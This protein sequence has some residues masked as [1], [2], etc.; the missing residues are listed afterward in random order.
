[1]KTPF[2]IHRCDSGR[3]RLPAR[4]AC[5]VAAAWVLLLMVA[6]PVHAQSDVEVEA[7]TDRMEVGTESVVTYKITVRGVSPSAVETPEPPPTTNLVLNN[8]T[9]VTRRDLSFKSGKMGRAISFEW[10]FRPMRVG[11]AR[12]R[13]TDVV[14]DGEA[15]TTGE[16]RVRVV[17]Q[18]Q[19]PTASAGPTGPD[20][21]RPQDQTPAP[22][23]LRTEDLF[24]NVTASTDRVYQNEQAMIEY[25][26]F[27]RPGIQLRH[28][29]LASAWDANG[30]WREELDV[31]SR[32][33]PENDRVDGEI[34]RTIVLKR[35]AVFPTR[36]GSLNVDPLQI[37]T[38]AYSADAS[39][40]RNRFRSQNRYEPVKLSSESIALDVLDLPDGAP[41]SFSGAVGSFSLEARVDADTARVGGT[42]RLRVTVKGSGNIA[43]LQ[44]PALDVPAAFDAYDPQVETEMDRAG[45]RVRG[46]KTFTY[47]L[48][49]GENGRYTL[50]PT[51]FSYF[52]PASERYVA[53][54]TEP[55]PL[56]VTGDAA[57]AAL[58]TTGAGL[59]VGDIAGPMASPDLAA[60]P[61]EP[62]HRHVWP[63]VAFLLPLLL[64]G[65]LIAVR[66][67]RE[68][69]AP[70]ARETAD[71]RLEEAESLIRSEEAPEAYAMFERAV[72]GFIGDRTGVSVAGFSRD[73]LDGFLEDAGADRDHRDGLRELLDA[74][75]QARFGPVS[76]SRDA[77]QI[78]LRRTRTLIRY[79]DDRLPDS[80]D[81]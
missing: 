38:E 8:P 43:T 34:Y 62:L 60:A 31:A 67:T 63:Y 24:I 22:L 18:S 54:V 75:D 51:T 78:A 11:I 30:F 53:L 45:S 13:E 46:T 70:P 6:V 39:R 21:Q 14:I 10:R 7:S 15:Y 3:G 28:S 49:P 66:G 56:H 73:R 12:L 57:P 68:R 69:S 33:I 27:F 47:I 40:R 48:V 41:P 61:S 5:A 29:R 16:V 20:R 74:C 26:L 80:A 19:A 64:A 76:P 42:V 79:F 4:Y 77:M 9:P 71:A 81:R 36:T 25:R 55:I 50:P 72:L 32:P 37:E 65:G 52:D 2:S 23:S 44:P 1:M 58:G 59:P 35:V 17:P